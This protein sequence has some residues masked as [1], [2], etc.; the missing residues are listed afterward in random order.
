MGK[1]V[2]ELDGGG[3]KFYR[4]RIM[5]SQENIIFTQFH[6]GRSFDF[7]KHQ[8][9]SKIDLFSKTNCKSNAIT[10]ARLDRKKSSPHFFFLKTNYRPLFSLCKTVLPPVYSSQK[11]RPFFPLK[12]QSPPLSFSFEK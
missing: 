2:K 1:R 5:G 3:S 12:I 7:K 4:S 10:F 9:I 8:I 11:L 6:K